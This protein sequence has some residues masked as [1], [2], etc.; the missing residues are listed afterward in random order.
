M[1]YILEAQKF[2]WNSTSDHKGYIKKIFETQQDAYNYYNKFNPDMPQLSDQNRCSDWDPKTYLIYIVREHFYEYLN[3]EPF[4][5][6][7]ENEN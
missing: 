1:P 4:E 3:L 5:N 6:Q 7:H 2:N